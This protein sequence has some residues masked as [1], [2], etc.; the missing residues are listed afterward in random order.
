MINLNNDFKKGRNEFK[1]KHYEDALIH[2][3]KISEG[4]ED[5]EYSL[6]YRIGC[7]IELK[8]YEDALEIIDPLIGKNPYDELLWFDKVTCHIFLKED[9]KA[10]RALDEIERIV[11]R[12][13]KRRLVC[14]AKFYNMLGDFDNS[15]RYCE[16]ALAID[17]NY[18]DALYEKS[19]VAIRLNDVDMIEEIANRLFEISNRDILSLTP[20]IL[21]KLFSKNYSACLDLIEN[22][23]DDEVKDET[24]EMFK[25]IVYKEL[26]EELNAQI[27]MSKEIDLSID[28]ALKLMFD[29]KEN[30]C[31]HGEI[32]GV[33]YMII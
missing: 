32:Y 2:F 13:D 27:L 8:C 25:F 10:F 14:V 17:E 19:H 1:Q 5:F 7:L 16:E 31:N 4:D 6:V 12:S 26:S 11:D 23:I 21:L 24:I 33:K 22:S 20:V 30:G 9:E 3:D 29:F 18:K 15:L 28:D